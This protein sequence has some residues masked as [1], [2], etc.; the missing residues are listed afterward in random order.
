M[1]YLRLRWLLALCLLGALILWQSGRNPS[2]WAQSPL[3]QGAGWS[4]PV[5]LSSSFPTAFLPDIAADQAGNLY[6]V[7]DTLFEEREGGRWSDGI[8]LTMWDGATW[9]PSVDIFGLEI[10]HL[11]AIAVDSEGRLHLIGVGET[12]LGYSRAWAQLR[13]T[14]AHA[15]S[16]PVDLAGGYVPYWNDI[17]VDSRNWIHVVFSSSESTDSQ[18]CVT[19]LC[20]SIF[21]TK[22]TNGGDSWS[23]PL[24]ISSLIGGGRVQIT[25]D[26][27]DNLYV[28]WS[29]EAVKR[30]GNF[31]S[32]PNGFTYSLDGGVSWSEPESPVFAPRTW[33][34]PTLGEWVSIA[35]DSQQVVHLMAVSPDEI[36]HVYRQGINGPWIEVTVPDMEGLSPGYGFRWIAVDGDDYLHLIL[37]MQHS[38]N[39]PA[40]LLHAVW[41]RA[42][43]W[44]SWDR[45]TSTHASGCGLGNLA[46]SQGNRLD[47]VWFE[48]T[49][50]TF[51][52]NN[53][54]YYASLQTGARAMPQVSLPP[55]P[56]PTALATTA[57]P[58]ST[59]QPIAS[60][61]LI[62]VASP[63]V[64]VGVA[65]MSRSAPV[66]G[67]AVGIGATVLILVTVI[68]IV[69]LRRR[70]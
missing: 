13:P 59:S 22:S 1:K 8:G 2:L 12:G 61:A 57:Q 69:T 51:L 36:R 35:V 63:T 15:W 20:T 5:S 43:G 47:V 56:T 39:S 24:R 53:E 60:A 3:E 17:V 46:I 48:Y 40:G 11:P 34:N 28:A 52:G 27:S 45:A 6:V 54:V 21:Y 65:P 26:K 70:R 32:G 50:A 41:N 23:R 30:D 68:G 62:L 18:E 29:N 14:D 55:M 31:I 16:Y 66:G 10:N 49:D 42:S 33:Y 25:V 37:P 64:I 4:E 7:W 67:L 9:S 58:T 38:T 19:E 44:S